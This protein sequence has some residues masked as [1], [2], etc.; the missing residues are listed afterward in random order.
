[1]EYDDLRY[2]TMKTL[3]EL[4]KSHSDVSS[5]IMCN[6]PCLSL[7]L[8]LLEIGDLI[9]VLRLCGTLTGSSFWKLLN[10]TNEG[11]IKSSATGI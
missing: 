7:A 11:T 8:S 1:M 3:L 6:G 2:F 10:T 5:L 4:F 9:V